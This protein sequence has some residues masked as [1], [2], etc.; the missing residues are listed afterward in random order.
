MDIEETR[1][2]GNES[3]YL[4]KLNVNIEET[5]ETALHALTFS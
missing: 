4:V 1:L 5:I 2:L 3:L